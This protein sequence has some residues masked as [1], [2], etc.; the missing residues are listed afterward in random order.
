M[1]TVIVTAPF[2]NLHYRRPRFEIKPSACTKPARLARGKAGTAIQFQRREL[3]AVP[4]L[5][6]R[7]ASVHL[8]RVT[9]PAPAPFGTA[10]RT[11]SNRPPPWLCV[12]RL[13]PGPAR[14]PG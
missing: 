11:P 1:L 10:V 13:P 5:R 8:W 7:F 14:N 9:A 2:Q 6:R 4:V 12:P 3:V